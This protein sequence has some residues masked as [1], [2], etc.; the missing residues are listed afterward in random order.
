MTG[1]R[2]IHYFGGSD[3]L[4]FMLSLIDKGDLT[5]AERNEL[6]AII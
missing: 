1:G 5:T 6:S 2:T 4:L 3:V